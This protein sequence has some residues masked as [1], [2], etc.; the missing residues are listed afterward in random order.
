MKVHLQ[1]YFRA[2]LLQSPF[3]TSTFL[4]TQ[5]CRD[6]MIVMR[7]EDLRL[8][9]S[10]RYRARVGFRTWRNEQQTWVVA[11]P[12]CLELPP[13][14]KVEGLLC[15]NPRRAADCAI[16]EKFAREECVR[17]LFLSPDLNA[18]VDAEISWP[19]VQRENVR[20]MVHAMELSV[21]GEKLS[22]IF[23]PD[24]EQ[25]RQ[26]FHALLNALETQDVV[27]EG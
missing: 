11:V 7:V 1:E 22:S 27:R 5:E 2:F 24:F 23:D 26:E 14:F 19:P 6:P 20:R 3:Y 10:D 21:I 15:L 8:F 12:F 13:Q 16:I 4:I 17:F 9:A 25:A 18:S